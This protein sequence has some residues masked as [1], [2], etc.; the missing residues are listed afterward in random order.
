[1]KMGS[2]ISTCFCNW[3]ENTSAQ[4][5]DSSIWYPQQDQ[6]I[7]METIRELV[8]APTSSPMSRRKETLL[9]GE[10]SRSTDEVLEEVSKRLTIVMPRQST[11][12]Q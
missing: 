12:D 2:L 5:K 11:P 9:N 4:I 7:F 6:P 1:M 10:H 8:P 3:K